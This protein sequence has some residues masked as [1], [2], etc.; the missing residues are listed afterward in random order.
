M[1]ARKVYENPEVYLIEVPFQNVALSETNVYVVRDGDDVLIVDMGSPTDEA[2]AVFAA[3]L[4]ELG[5]DPSK[6][7]YAFTHM[8]FDHSGLARA[9]IPSTA[10]I[11]IHEHERASARPDF[12]EKMNR[13]VKRRLEEE[14]MDSA[15]ASLMCASI[16]IATPLDDGSKTIETVRGGDVI[17]VGRHG[18]EV[19]DLPGHTRGMMGLYQPDSGICFSGDQLL[20]IIT[21][22]TGLFLDGSDS[23]LAY[24][25]SQQRLLSLPIT[26]LFHSHGEIRPDFRERGVQ[27]LQHKNRRLDVTADAV[28]R[29]YEQADGQLAP[30]G[31]DVIRAMGWNIPFGSIDECEAHQQWLI[32]TQGIAILD[33]MVVTG[34]IDRVEEPAMAGVASV[35]HRYQSVFS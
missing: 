22:T 2:A 34:R 1:I 8:H 3:A 25:R 20:F 10:T 16:E 30:R 12:T 26:M 32:Y 23:L 27:I 15:Q 21:T 24:E 5:I 17:E 4:D 35:L 31:I 19:V 28:K 14:G 13:I 9:Y 11:Y 6:A 7:R 18:F 33:H 29:L